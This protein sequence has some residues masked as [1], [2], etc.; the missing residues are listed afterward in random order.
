MKVVPGSG[1]ILMPTFNSEYGVTHISVIDGGSG[2]S[3]E[4]P[5]K[6]SIR[7]A[8][9]PISEG[10]FY[11]IIID[12]VIAGVRVVY[13]G[14]G[15]FPVSSGTTATAVAFIN[16]LGQLSSIKITNAGAGYTEAPTITI[17]AGSTVSS[18]NF[19]FGETVTSSISGAIGIVQNWDP[20]TKQLKV[21]GISTDFIVGDIIVGE[22]SNSTYTITQYASASSSTPYDDNDT[23]EQEADQIIDFSESNPFGEV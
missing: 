15:Y 18:G 9:E 2:Y 23:I 22:S 3:D 5:P 8:A 20:Y 21:S 6:I 1:A 17:G 12:G 7:D 16:D 4:D 11:P 10:I 19:I 13:S 14:E